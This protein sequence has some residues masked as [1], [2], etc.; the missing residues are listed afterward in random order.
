M[1]GNAFVYNIATNT[2]T[3][4]NRPTSGGTAVS[5]TA[6]GIYGNQIVGGS[7]D[8]GA[9]GLTHAYMLNQSTGV[10][11]IYD[12]PG[13]TTVTHF[14]GVTGGGR[15]NTY[16]LVADSVDITG[17]AHAWAV[18]VEAVM[19]VLDRGHAQPLRAQQRQ[20]CDQQR[21]LAAAGPA[22]DS[23]DFHK[24]KPFMRWAG[25]SRGAGRWSDNPS[26]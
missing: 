5:T 10:Y 13:P 2:Y 25:F 20:Q 1:T 3:T 21:G 19:R 18:H 11:T 6:Y 16:N 26:R 22:D 7:T 17:Q 14:E 24:A 9:G 23:Q 15:A 8:P 4:I 12:A